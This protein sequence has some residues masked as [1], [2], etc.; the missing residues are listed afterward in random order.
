MQ[1]QPVLISQY[2]AAL[3]MLR[4]AVERCPDDLWDA[5]Q[6]ANPF[7]RVAYHALF[8][9]QL[10]LSRTL[11]DFRPWERHAPG[12]EDMGK[13]YSGPRYT[14]GD[15]LDYLAFCQQLTATN[16]ADLDLEGPS[17]F[18]WCRFNKLE[19]QFYNIRHLQQH[20]GELMERLGARA[21]VSVDWISRG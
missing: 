5:S 9:T 13:T 2:S 21:G 14:C 16:T 17:G 8:F 20:T 19:L 15:V 11:A 10:Y 6:D 18:D 12:V 7:W 1:I 3:A 4:Q